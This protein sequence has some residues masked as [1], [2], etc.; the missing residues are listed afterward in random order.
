VQVNFAPGDVDEWMSYAWESDNRVAANGTDHS[1]ITVGLR[2]AT[3]NILSGRKVVLASNNNNT[4]IA[5]VDDVVTNSE[6]EAFFKVTNT[7]AETVRYTVKDVATG[8]T[9]AQSIQIR[10][11]AVDLDLTKSGVVASSTQVS[12]DGIDVSKISVTIKDKK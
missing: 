9:L 2:D 10:F 12:A 1:V 6:G 7:V 4:R 11:T 5:A 3:G 8:L